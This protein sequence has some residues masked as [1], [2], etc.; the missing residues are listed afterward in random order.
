LDHFG[1]RSPYGILGGVGVFIGPWWAA[2][3]TLLKHCISLY[4][5]YWQFVL[6]LLIILSSSSCQGFQ[7]SKN[8]FSSRT[9]QS[10]KVPCFCRSKLAKDLR[11][12]DGRLHVNLNVEEGAVGG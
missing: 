10:L 6:G 7:V 12:V 8:R 2:I 9:Q 1:Q 3:I 4:T 11:K 5:Y